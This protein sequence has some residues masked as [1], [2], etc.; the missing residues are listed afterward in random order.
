M[1]S[2]MGVGP[3]ARRSSSTDLVA[4][5]RHQHAAQVQ[6]GQ[7]E[8]RT[9][10]RSTIIKIIV[11]VVLVAAASVA[12]W[13][14]FNKYRL[15]SAISAA[16]THL[17]VGTIDELELAAASLDK[18]LSV[19]PNDDESHAL[20]ALV[21]AH[22]AVLGVET[23]AFAASLE[24]VSDSEEPEAQVAR[25]ISA[26][27]SGDLDTVQGVLE[28]VDASSE[29]KPIARTRAWLH[30]TVAL[31]QVFDRDQ[32]A[33]AITE[34]EGVIEDEA[35]TPPH[36]WLAA[37]LSRVGRVDD[38]LG[39]LEAARE[40]NPADLGIAVDEALIHAVLAEHTGGVREVAD[41]LLADERLA[42][43]D[44]GRLHLARALVGLRKD[45]FDKIGSELDEAWKN[46]PEWDLDS[47]AIVIETALVGGDV[48]RG[49]KWLDAIEADE[50]TKKA[51]GAWIELQRGNVAK[52]L[53][54]SAKLEQSHPRVAYVQALALVE[55]KRFPEAGPWLERAQAFYGKRV[56]LRVAQA[57]H[58]AHT[59]DPKK[60]AKALDDIVEDN[61]TRR[62]LTGL[63]EA[64][65]LAAGEEGKTKD[66]EKALRRAIEKEDKPAE[67]AFLLGALLEKQAKEEP[68]KVPEAIELLRKAAEVDA[69]TLRYRVELG[70]LLADYG[71]LE[72]AQK[73]LLTL[74][75]E[76]L[77]PGQALLALANVTL[78]RIELGHEKLD[79][80][81]VTKTLESATKKGA[82][83]LGVAVAQARLTLAGGDAKLTTAVNTLYSLLSANPKHMQTRLLYGE[84]LR[85]NKD[86]TNARLVLKESQG[87]S[88]A[89]E[90]RL[91][92]ARAAVER[93]D[94]SDRLA[95]SIA[96]KGWLKLTKADMPANERIRLA[97]DAAA[98][99][100]E[101]DNRQVPRSISKSVV[102]ELPWRADALAFRALT[103]LADDKNEDGCANAKKA[104]KL[105]KE[106]G[107]A[108][109]A[110]AEC[111]ISKH[112]YTDARASYKKA[113]QLALSG[114]EARKYKRR[115][116]VLR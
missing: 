111:F 78:E 24:D 110:E 63:G 52:S 98:Y 65:L 28:K 17:A 57:R 112:R 49:E 80:A 32:L 36:R 10:R 4:E 3:D 54:T 108:H 48:E 113:V 7:R 8:R 91:L 75:E 85:R 27:L 99:W 109:A 56:E 15:S 1:P 58:D 59:G 37:L 88:D 107:E 9:R 50:T 34:L 51:Y 20:L 42:D 76:E 53:E 41:R 19:A 62:G 16:R 101:I 92:I 74:D 102:D 26:A 46:L 44:R 94:G 71:D 39:R 115:L 89:D 106:L 90:G 11:A 35:W 97:R 55:Q 2:G 43:R 14:G 104:M 105:D 25:G 116:R 5:L 68:K 100:E 84:A 93:S 29:S 30:G 81:K 60:A 103:Q 114:A 33:G 86:Y 87:D 64:E 61:H 77:A 83:P 79:E 96:W 21:R 40:A 67:A 13:L 45:G 6:Q 73:V 31:G 38:A 18:G 95:A 12:G 72:E 22:Q 66:A 70:Q 47:R 69:D 82:P 23:E